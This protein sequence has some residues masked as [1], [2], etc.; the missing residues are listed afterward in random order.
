MRHAAR[1]DKRPQIGARPARDQRQA[2]QTTRQQAL[3]KA[4]LQRGQ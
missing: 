2:Q 3:A 4:A 1:I